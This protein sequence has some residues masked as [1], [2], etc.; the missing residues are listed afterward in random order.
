MEL[1]KALEEGMSLTIQK[2]VTI[3]DAALH[4]GSGKIQDLFAT[5]RLVALMIEASTQLIDGPLPE[6]YVSVGH[7]FE[8]DHF[9]PTLVGATVTIEVKISKVVDNRYTLDM[10]AYDEF[11]PIGS[12]Q[13]TRSIVDYKI[14]VKRAQDR[15]RAGK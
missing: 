4:Y 12:G 7:H 1:K 2:K 10:N 15:E 13:H 11:G 8:V 5:P 3:D 9:K 6:G 14:L